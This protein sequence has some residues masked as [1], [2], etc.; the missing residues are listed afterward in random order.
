MHPLEVAGTT[1]EKVKTVVATR[2]KDVM[3][4]KEKLVALHNR[5]SLI[6]PTHVPDSR[7]YFLM[8][9]HVGGKGMHT[10]MVCQNVDFVAQK[11]ER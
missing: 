10:K 2:T 11:V 1:L 4:G 5:V 8:C 3:K 9:M 6:F 7:T